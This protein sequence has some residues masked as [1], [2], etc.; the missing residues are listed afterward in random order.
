MGLWSRFRLSAAQLVTRCCRTARW[1]AGLRATARQE[2][3]ATAPTSAATPSTA[4]N[5]AGCS[6]SRH[7][8]TRQRSV[9]VDLGVRNTFALEQH[10]RDPLSGTQ[11]ITGASANAQ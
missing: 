10:Q 11:G 7:A 3:T 8:E 9:V 2:C 5:A 4:P 1:S 6:A